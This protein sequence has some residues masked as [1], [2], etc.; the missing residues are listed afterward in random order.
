MRNDSF[1]IL[2]WS[3]FHTHVDGTVH[4]CC[5]SHRPVLN[6]CGGNAS[7][8][9]EKPLAIWNG[10]DFTKIR[11]AMLEG[12]RIPHCQVCYD[13][14][15]NGFVSRRQNM[16][17]FFPQHRDTESNFRDCII[18]PSSPL[19]AKPPIYF[20]IRLGN[21]CNLKCRMCGPESSSQLEGD[22]VA[23]KWHSS[24]ETPRV[25]LDVSEWPEAVDL[26]EQLKVFCVGAVR[27]DLMGG[28]PTLN[29]S[30]L[31]ILEYMVEKNL[32]M[33]VDLGIISNLTNVRK[34]AF[35]LFGM[36]KSTEI[37][38]SIDGIGSVY[39]YIRF[40]GRWDAVSRNIKQL[41]ASYPNFKLKAFPT[42]QAYNILNLTEILDWCVE[43]HLFCELGN[44]LFLPP[45]LNVFVLPA[46][47]RQT[48]ALKLT[49]WL[50]SQKTDKYVNN[51]EVQR[52][53]EY[54]LDTSKG[55][56]P[57]DVQ[58]FAQYTIDLDRSRNQHMEKMV[59]EVWDSLFKAGLPAPGE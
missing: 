4:L 52:I 6:S 9:H 44:I 31:E 34:R 20:D 41:Q 35:D 22:E 19:T 5:L 48:A 1:C 43:N 38:I 16:N 37:R 21:I 2:A 26:L 13:H 55:S 17:Q 27:I 54:L 56:S 49:N 29:E 11:R 50:A 36:F 58:N 53:I 3:H 18:D 8:R 33:N 7:I 47:A 32:A 28:E 25:G 40:P 12:E 39:D 46:A 42:I 45:Y 57:Q 30:Q 15:A 24:P 59:P 23:V 51:D 14:E 10:D